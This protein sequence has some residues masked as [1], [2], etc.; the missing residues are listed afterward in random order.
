MRLPV[1]AVSAI[2]FASLHD[3]P[4]QAISFTGGTLTEDFDGMGAAGTGTPAGW[5]VGWHNGYP[6]GT[7]GAVVRDN[8]VT[9]NAGTTA[10]GGAIAGFN[11]GVSGDPDRS[12]GTAPTATSSPNG[13]N[14]FIEVQIQNDS[15]QTLKAIQISYVGKQ[16]RTSS[17]SSGQSFTNFLQYGT[18]GVNFVFMGPG[19][20]F[21]APV[22]G[23]ASTPLNGNLFGNSIAGLG[24]FYSLPALLPPG[25]RMHLRWLDVN[26]PSTDPVLAIDKFSFRGLTNIPEVVIANGDFGYTFSR[27]AGMTGVSG[28]NNGSGTEAQFTGPHA[29][30]A[31]RHGNLYVADTGNHVIRRITP[32]GEVSTFAGLART[33][34]TNDGTGGNA[35]FYQ[36]EGVCVDPKGNLFVSEI[37]NH[38]IRKITPQRVVTTVAGLWGTT[39][40]NDGN[41]N[42]A[43]FHT[44]VT[45]QVDDEGFLYVGDYNNHTIR[46]IT[47]TGDV[48]TLAGLA[49]VPGSDN[50]P[51]AQ[52]RF[53]YPHT[54]LPDGQ[55]N[56]YVADLGNHAIRKISADGFVSTFA[57][58][59]GSGG[60]NDGLGT[61][62]RFASP[63]GL[64]FEVTGNLLVTDRE[65][66]TVR[67]IAP[68]R[69][70]KTIAGIARVD[71]SADGRGT[72]AT[73]FRPRGIAV[74]PNGTL[75]IV[76]T[77]NQ[78]IRIGRPDP[79][80]LAT[81]SSGNMILSWPSW[82]TNFLLESSLTLPPEN[83]GPVSFD[84]AAAGNFNF[85]TNPPT[86]PARFFR[87]RRL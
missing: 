13:T 22:T 23:P 29:M 49:D 21:E 85:L 47:P 83:W 46:R 11:C 15:G 68:D 61:L 81:L 78:T 60:T 50:G 5:F 70:V 32:E 80:L 57:G 34:G 36:P 52:A 9:V 41:G 67:R 45:I 17:S 7:A 31:D 35:R 12:L 65:N 79:T 4:A 87:L 63:W 14:R 8:S 58:L 59:P 66:N 53:K 75:F 84:P 2:L 64:V 55:G 72:T 6:S 28:T 40:T 39:G 82:T 51:V 44:P 24:G 86:E 30:A 25:G 71:G 76:D 77:A 37:G 1:V 18:D 16:W 56:I 19:F 74:A 33:M 10:P 73:F 3:L 20:D 38:T 27:F 69:T 26:D 48:S 54:C 43:R 62:A 42:A